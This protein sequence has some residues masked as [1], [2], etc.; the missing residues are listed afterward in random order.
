MCAGSQAADRACELQRGGGALPLRAVQ[1][2]DFNGG[3]FRGDTH[4]DQVV[5][6]GSLPKADAAER[7]VFPI[8]PALAV[9]A[10]VDPLIVHPQAQPVVHVGEAQIISARPLHGGLGGAQ[11]DDLLVVAAAGIGIEQHRLAG[12]QIESAT[13]L[14]G[15]FVEFQQQ[16]ALGGLFDVDL[17]IQR[18]IAHPIIPGPVIV[19]AGGSR[20]GV[21]AAEISDDLQP[22]PRGQ[23]RPRVPLLG[24]FPSGPIL[25]AGTMCR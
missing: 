20:I 25:G 12:R 6:I 21:V 19:R 18:Q 5:I 8:G 4:G 16:F 14:S 23:F 11:G 22:L 9:G 2:R 7:L 1:V 13:V 17:A 3:P 10:E 24:F 15:P